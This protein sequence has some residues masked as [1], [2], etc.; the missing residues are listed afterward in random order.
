MCACHRHHH[1]NSA[2]SIGSRPSPVARSL[3]WLGRT[4]TSQQAIHLPFCIATL[5]AV[6]VAAVGRR[7]RRHR[8]ELQTH[9]A[10]CVC[11]CLRVNRFTPTASSASR[12]VGTVVVVVVAAPRWGNGI[13][14]HYTHAGHTPLLRALPPD[15][16]ECIECIIITPLMLRLGKVTFC[17]FELRARRESV[18]WSCGR[19]WWRAHS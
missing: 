7:R 13:H 3:C 9:M 18:S 19:R 1:H 14:G 4:R 10:L 8:Q 2:P 6:V 12:R 11:V 5:L 16:P 15:S 17:E